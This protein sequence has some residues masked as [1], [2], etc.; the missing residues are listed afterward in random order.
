[1]RRDGNIWEY[2]AVYVN[3]LAFAMRDPQTF[4]NVLKEKHKFKLKGTGDI[5]FHLGCDFF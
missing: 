3:D 2:A 4:V 5:V 1:M